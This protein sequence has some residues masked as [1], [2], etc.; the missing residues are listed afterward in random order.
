MVVLVSLSIS[1]PIILTTHFIL[2][3]NSNVYLLLSWMPVWLRIHWIT[4]GLYGSFWLWIQ[5]A[6]WS[7]LVLFMVLCSAYA[8]LIIPL[9]RTEL[10]K[11][12]EGYKTRDS[13]RLA[14]N[15]TWE[16]RRIEVLHLNVNDTFGWLVI[17]EQAL[18]ADSIMF[19]NYALITIWDELDGPTAAVLIIFAGTLLLV[20]FSILEA[21]GVFHKYAV[22]LLES[23]KYCKWSNKR[24]TL[25]MNKF[26]K[27]C[28]PLAI[29]SGGVYA[30]GRLTG[31]KFVQG[32]ISG[33]LRILL[34]T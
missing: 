6:F 14:K 21:S 13:L 18:I 16:Y 17:P 1:S 32:I 28:K 19:C 15:I 3:P 24:E 4:V 20:F 2:Y 23:W 12:R 31:Q 26:R 9:V 8:A 30:V 33:T 29:R 10:V 27:S 25:L 11:G 5:F 22:E 34:A 7:T